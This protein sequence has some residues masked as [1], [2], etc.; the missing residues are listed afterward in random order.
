MSP[1]PNWRSRATPGSPPPSTSS[2]RRRR[3]PRPRRRS[4]PWRCCGRRARSTTS[5]ARCRRCPAWRPPRNS[6]AA[7]SVRG[8]SPDQN[9]TMMDGVEIHDPYR[10]FG[11]TSAFNPET[12]QRFE[13]ATGGFSVKYGDRLSSLLVVENREGSA[14]E[15][16]ERLGVAQ[17][18]RRQRRARRR[19][20]RQ[21]HGLV[22]RDRPPHLLRPGGRARH[23]SA[24]SRASPTCRPRA[25]GSRRPAASVTLFGLTQPAGRGDRDRRRRRA[26]R[27]QGRHRQRPGV[28]ALRRLARHARAVAHRSP[29]TPTRD[30]PSASMPRSRTRA[31]ARTR[32]AT[33]SFGTA[34]VVFER[35]LTVRDVSLRQ[36][37]AWALGAHVVEDRRRG[38]SPVDGPAL[39]GRR[40]IAIRPAANGSSVQGGAGLPDLL[41]SS[42]DSTRGGAW[43]QDTLAGS[44]PRGSLQAGLRLDYA[45]VTGETA[46]VAARCR[47]PSA[48]D[49]STRLKAAVGRYTQS[50]GYEKLA[51]SDYV[52]DFTNDAVRSLRSERAVQASAGLERDLG[53]AVSHAGRGLLQALHRSADRP[54]RDRGRARWRAWRATTFPLGARIEHPGRSDHHHRADQ[55]RPRA[56][57]TASICSSR[58]RRRRPSA[59]SPAGRAT[60]GARPIAMPTA[61]AIR[62]NTTAGT[63]SR[64][65]RR[66]GSRRAG[67]WRRRPRVAS[68]FPRTAP[69]GVRVVG[70]EDDARRATATA[71]PTSSCPSATRSGLLV[72]AVDFGGATTSTGARL[73]LFARVDVR[74]TWRPRGAAGRWEFYA[75]VINLLNRKNAGAY[76]PRLEYDPA[77]D[78][79]PIVEERDQ[80]IPRLPTVGVRF[81]S[82]EHPCSVT[83]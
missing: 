4:N 34:N 37:L 40:A 83:G 15:G 33:S 62:S 60:P 14:G 59:G 10:L 3:S 74:A 43:L 42:Q 21:G 16:L 46:A 48:S 77:S 64:W 45:G 28:A 23:R 22:A 25:C 65:W 56:A 63:R 38:A 12:I 58:A 49:P 29:A 61:V 54:A 66:T 75:E 81:Q 70:A 55:R 68:G 2:R 51:Q 31:S 32:P 47:A 39:R 52:L 53:R 9:L 71:S 79:P 35:A 5:I 69:L 19:A 80:S 78:R 67:S 73:P 26:R 41:A 36:E 8:G 57:P 82:K 50:P 6:A 27:V 20:A 44:A 13:L 72:Y 7:S 1:T 11:L 30:R 24:V 76:E 18:H 17:H